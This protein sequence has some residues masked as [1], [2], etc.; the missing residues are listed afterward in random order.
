M[1]NLPLYVSLTFG[2]TV[3]AAV[4]LFL[5]AAHYSRSVLILISAWVV[6]QS[7]LSSTGFYHAENSASARFPILFLPPLIFIIGLFL[8]KQGRLFIDS[9]DLG[10]LTIFHVVRI[11]VELVLFWL[12][13]YKLIPEA[14][15]FE[16]RNFDIISGLSA[17]LVYYFG[18]VKKNLNKSILL[19]WNF[20]CLALLINVVSNALLSLPVRFQHFG[21]EQPN[22]G[23]GYFPFV[24]LPACLV[25]L[26]L[27]SNAAAIRQ[28]L[29]HKAIPQ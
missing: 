3:I 21:F 17:P 25:P 1:N 24:L 28:L 15:S 12:V 13:V 22:I 26:A 5:R 23:L 20:L 7:L 4:W 11:P 6:I 29:S 14:M 10:A 9:L 19:A 27:F 8:T 16:G 18:F 2:T